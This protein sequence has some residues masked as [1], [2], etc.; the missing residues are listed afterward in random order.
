MNEKKI[1]VLLSKADFYKLCFIGFGGIFLLE[2]ITP[3][4]KMNYYK[5]FGSMVLAFAFLWGMIRSWDMAAEKID[6]ENNRG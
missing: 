6:E 3:E 5:L 1:D 4:D 2:L